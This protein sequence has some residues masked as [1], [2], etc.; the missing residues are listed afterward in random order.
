M[1]PRPFDATKVLPTPL[2]LLLDESRPGCEHYSAFKVGVLFGKPD[3]PGV[4]PEDL[5]AGNDEA[6]KMKGCQLLTQRLAPL[7]S[8]RQ[9]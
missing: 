5:A 6:S 9:R 3:T 7:V 8:P 4:I 2:Y 1:L